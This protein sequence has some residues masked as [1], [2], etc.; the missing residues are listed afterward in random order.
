[1]SSG[2]SG[3]G[4]RGDE[5]LGLCWQVEAD[6]SG[7]D[8]R[9]ATKRQWPPP[10]DLPVA[11]RGVHIKIRLSKRPFPRRP[12]CCVRVF[13]T[14]GRSKTAKPKTCKREDAA[15]VCLEMLHAFQTGLCV[16]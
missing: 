4:P 3:E 9:F 2:R 11:E 12:P 15:G 7:R 5:P 8:A 16:P 6:T 10:A 14:H 13:G 1:M